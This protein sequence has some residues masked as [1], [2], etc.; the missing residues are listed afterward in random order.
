MLK[1][2]GRM[3]TIAPCAV[4]EPFEN[5]GQALLIV[6]TRSALEF[7]ITLFI[8]QPLTTAGTLG[9]TFAETANAVGRS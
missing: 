6:F 2:A 9:C 3:G 5:Y 8:R 7:D 4:T 1:I